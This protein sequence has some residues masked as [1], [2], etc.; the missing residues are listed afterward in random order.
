MESTL[1]NITHRYHPQ[2]LSSS[3]HH[4][5]LA[6]K[7]IIF[8]KSP[9][10]PSLTTI[11]SSI[12][13]PNHKAPKHQTP[14]PIN[15]TRKSLLKTTVITGVTVAAV[16][17]SQF[18][19]KPSIAAPISSSPPPATVETLEEEQTLEQHLCTHPDDIKALKTLMEIKIKTGKVQEAIR[20]LNQLINLEPEDS[21]W[22]LLK[23]HLHSYAGDH[24]SAK[25]GFEEIITKDPF[26]VEAYHGLV[27]AASAKESPNELKEVENRILEGIE[28]CKKAKKKDDMRDFKLLL[29]QI[30]VIQSD[31]DDAIKIYQELSKE[32]PRDFRPYLCQ[33]IIH[34]LLGKNDD[35]ENMFGKYRRLVPKGHP[36]TKYFDENM[37][38]TK[39]FA[40]KLENDRAYSKS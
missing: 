1:T 30:R 17:L 33:G 24:D 2:P 26:R 12:R 21:E 38:A 18:S 15:P 25:L 6:S 9:S 13:N 40:Q 31:Y 14:K 7:S 4:R 36:Y 3:H 28:S 8:P 20:I 34:T 32:E 35:A 29:A 39:V 22:Q 16:F 37:I 27:M 23:H 19:V 10:F 5:H 11:R